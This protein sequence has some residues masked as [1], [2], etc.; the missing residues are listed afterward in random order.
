MAGMIAKRSQ[1]FSALLEWVA[2]LPRPRRDYTQESASAFLSLEFYHRLATL[3]ACYMVL[4]RTFAA[5]LAQG[6]IAEP[7][8]REGGLSLQDIIDWHNRLTRR[9]LRE[10]YQ[11]YPDPLLIGFLVDLK[12]EMGFLEAEVARRFEKLP[13]TRALI[14]LDPEWMGTKAND[15][16]AVRN[17]V[18][19]LG[20]DKAVN[21][22]QDPRSGRAI[23]KV[24]PGVDQADA[25]SVA[26]PPPLFD[27][28]QEALLRVF[29]EWR[30]PGDSVESIGPKPGYP[31]PAEKML[32]VEQEFWDGPMA[33]VWE[34]GGQAIL[35]NQV[36]IL[37]GERESIGREVR[38]H[39]F[40]EQDRIIWHRARHA[41]N[42]QDIVDETYDMS[43]GIDERL[44]E[45]EAVRAIRKKAADAY[46][47]ASTRWKK[48]G[49]RFVRALLKGEN[50]TEASETAGISRQTGQKYLQ[51]LYRDLS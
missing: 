20:L 10:A 5:R 25:T 29:E 4:L 16:A 27:E 26:V 1:E 30:R 45:I 36:P 49:Q 42:G 2:K 24:R 39:V 46:R 34:I 9:V 22:F 35:N 28:Q 18:R 41:R 47:L 14:R 31:V 3:Q 21:R 15:P 13:I 33:R 6:W 12:S 48:R 8:L 50:N 43:P 19:L 37:S 40:N 23:I 11:T 38:G 17:V 7:V 32:P 51:G 44:I